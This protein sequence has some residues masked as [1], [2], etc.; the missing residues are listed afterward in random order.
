MKPS[1]PCRGSQL[2]NT[3]IKLSLCEHLQVRQL[4]KSL[5]VG[6][7]KQIQKDMIG[8]LL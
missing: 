5:L 1:Q 3:T 2:D 6:H 4:F 7:G 8:W